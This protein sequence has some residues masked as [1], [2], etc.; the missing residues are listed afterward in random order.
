LLPFIY[1]HTQRRGTVVVPYEQLSK[2]RG[3]INGVKE[4]EL[5]VVR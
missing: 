2:E 3:H 5:G 4:D 1:N